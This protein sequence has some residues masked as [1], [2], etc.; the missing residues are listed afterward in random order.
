MK[1][2]IK[3]VRL[4]PSEK[5]TGKRKKEREED[6]NK[7]EGR[8]KTSETESFRE[9]NRKKKGREEDRNKEM[10]AEIKLG[11]LSPSS[12][13]C[14]QSDAL[15]LFPVSHVSLIHSTFITAVYQRH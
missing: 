14:S 10:K 3:L 5:P 11:R 2:E 13:S 15:T 7:E 6:R 9:N 12:H 8:N 4:I 1:A